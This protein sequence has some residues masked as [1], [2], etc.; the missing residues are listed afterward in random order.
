MSVGTWGRM[1]NVDHQKKIREN[2]GTGKQRAFIKP[3]LADKNL[4]TKLK[5]TKTTSREND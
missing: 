5:K 4:C 1:G 3:E 2:V